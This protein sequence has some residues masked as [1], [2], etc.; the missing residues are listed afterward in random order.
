MHIFQKTIHPNKYYKWKQKRRAPEVSIFL[1][2]KGPQVRPPGWPPDWKKSFSAARKRVK[3]AFKC[4]FFLAVLVPE[5]PKNAKKRHFRNTLEGRFSCHFAP[6]AE[7]KSTGCPARSGGRS[8][9]ILLAKFRLAAVHPSSPPPQQGV[10][11]A[12]LGQ[13]PLGDESEILRQRMV[14]IRDK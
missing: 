5:V 13:P 11:Q 9:R 2:Q 6:V 12:L 10:L 14:N 3:M 1:D 4:V 8:N 7:K